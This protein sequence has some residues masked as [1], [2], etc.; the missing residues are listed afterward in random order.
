MKRVA[1]IILVA[2]F[3]VLG[4]AQNTA[5]EQLEYI[6]DNSIAATRT[7]D[8]NW[9]RSLAATGWGQGGFEGWKENR[10]TSWEDRKAARDRIRQ[11]RRE[12]R[13]NRRRYHLRDYTPA[14]ER[15]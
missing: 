7:D 9:A 3:P 13:A 5:R 1:I 12:A 14:Q 8:E 6:A 15:K 11:Q 2:L 4:R 10:R